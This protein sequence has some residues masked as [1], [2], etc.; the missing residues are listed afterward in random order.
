M[1]VHVRKRYAGLHTVTV[2]AVTDRSSHKPRARGAAGTLRAGSARAGVAG[3]GVGAAAQLRD[4]PH[5][6]VNVE[7]GADA[8]PRHR[9]TGSAGEHLGAGR[10]QDA[11]A[12]EGDAPLVDLLVPGPV[13]GG[14]VAG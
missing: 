2:T 14:A 7:P 12:G 5:P 10:V 13:R 1:H 9:V 8:V 3:P 11:L 4:E 6:V